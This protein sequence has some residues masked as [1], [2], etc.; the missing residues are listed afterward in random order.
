MNGWPQLELQPIGPLWLEIGVLLTTIGI[1]VY[2]VYATQYQPVKVRVISAFLR[3]LLLASG[4]FLLHHPTLTRQVIEPQ[5]SRMAVLI[6]RSGSMGAEVEDGSSRYQKAFD[7]LDDLRAAGTDFDVYEFDQTVS[8]PL[9]AVPAPRRLS[10]NRTD[11]YGSLSQ[12]LGKHSDYTS[13]TLLSDGHDLG[14]FSQ[15][16]VEDTRQWLNRLNAPPINTVLIGDQLSGPE[17]A[18]HSID[19]PAFS[20]VRAPLTIRATIIV[21]NLDGFQTQ[22]QLLD[23][24]NIIQIKD[25]VLDDQ[26]FGTVE[27]QFYPEQQGEHLYTIHI[28]PHH[29][30]TNTENNSQQVLVDIGRDKI[31]VLHISGSITWDLQGLR[32]MFERDPLVDLTAFYIMRTREHVQIGTDNRSIPHD[33]MALVPFPTE[34]IFDRQLFGFDVVVFQDFDAGNYFSD[35][36]QARRLM[37][38]IKEFVQNHHGGFVVVG[39]PRTAGGPSLGLTPLAEVLP[40][41]P[42]NYRT[43]FDA[44]THDSTL[45]D[46]GKNHPILRLFDGDTMKFTGTMAGV[47]LNE[48]AETLL[49]DQGGRPLLSVMEP[50]SGRTL[51]LNT[52]SSWQWQRDALAA[53]KT[54]ESYYDFWEQA[55]KWVIQDPSLNQVRITTSKTAADPLKLDIEVLLRQRNY[56]PAATT[57]AVLQVT[58]LDNR[59]DPVSLTFTTDYSGRA[60]KTFTAER[61]GYYRLAFTEG[62]WSELSRPRTLFLGGS[63]DELRNLDLVPETLQ[64]L[65]NYTNG[66]FQSR[67]DRFEGRQLAMKTPEDKHVIETHRV[68]IR[69]WIWSLPI[70]LLI[71]SLE[72]A[73]RR[74]SQLA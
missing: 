29:L 6:D 59:G 69:N 67:V 17:V 35:S 66:S 55:L 47:R 18:I 45:T 36:Y 61:P 39:G 15:M 31:S 40:L 72:W 74:S 44:E 42:P 2:S 52:S 8:E 25:L 26:G 70:L 13:L 73:V 14:R 64:R 60:E 10:G 51:F 56:Q 33:E 27:F 12:F 50:G 21:R 32:A 23:G 1:F 20:F 58:P 30:E 5:P 57:E 22:A 37:S 68:K 43:P 46:Q 48:G 53:G 3:F 34:E 16:S 11:F 41:V 9:G 4:Y 7:V 24:E 54:G 63:Q 49:R 65:A 71:A 19:A 62:P 38:K 28:P